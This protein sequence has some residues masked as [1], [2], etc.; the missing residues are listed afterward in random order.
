MTIERFEV[1]IFPFN[2][3]DMPAADSRGPAVRPA[4]VR[5]TGEQGASGY[6]R[7]IGDGVQAEIATDTGVVEA[8]T[9]DGAELE[10]GWSARAQTATGPS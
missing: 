10:D 9:V 3:Q 1:L 8:I 7:Y 6:P 4:I 2:E 5:P